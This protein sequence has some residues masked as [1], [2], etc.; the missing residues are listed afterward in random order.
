MKYPLSVH[1][2]MK[3]IPLSEYRSMLSEIQRLKM[4]NKTLKQENETLKS[5]KV[6]EC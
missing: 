2:P 6:S 5:G 3:E 4:E 1:P